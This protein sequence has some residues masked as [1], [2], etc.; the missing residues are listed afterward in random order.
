M[1][2][3]IYALSNS[4][5]YIDPKGLAVPSLGEMGIS[6][7]GRNMTLFD[8]NNYFNFPGPL[9]PVEGQCLVCDGDKFNKCMNMMAP[10]SGAICVPGSPESC[11]GKGS[12]AFALGACTLYACSYKDCDDKDDCGSK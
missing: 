5:R 4:L 6:T 3:Y 8:L 10:W 2:T 11:P 1:N 9:A 12:Q 7:S